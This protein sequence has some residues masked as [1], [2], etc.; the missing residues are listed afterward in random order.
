MVR[1]GVPFT[2]VGF[3]APLPLTGQQPAAHVLRRRAAALLSSNRGR[4]LLSSL[5]K[6]HNTA[7][8]PNHTSRRTCRTKQLRFSRAHDRR[9]RSCRRQRWKG[10]KA[11]GKKR[12]APAGPERW[13][14]FN[15]PFFPLSVP[16]P[17][18][19]SRSRGRRRSEERV[20]RMSHAG[21][22]PS[23]EKERKRER[24]WTQLLS[25]DPLPLVRNPS[26]SFFLVFFFCFLFVFFSYPPFEASPF[27]SKLAFFD[28]RFCFPARSRVRSSNP[29][30][31]R[32]RL[33]RTGHA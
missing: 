9:R 20:S 26:F 16:L 31:V 13:R 4:I 28:P 24:A 30:R 1:F 8:R 19:L 22:C 6:I 7:I 11:G 29:P 27:S 23:T 14:R 17:L 32:E 5:R 2:L 10:I 33:S 18:S 3:G 12:R 25:L 21:S 15:L